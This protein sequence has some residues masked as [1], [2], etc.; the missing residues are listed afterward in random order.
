MRHRPPN[1]HAVQKGRL[2][3]LGLAALLLAA[4]LSCSGGA[5]GPRNVIVVL[6][7]TLRADHLGCYG[8][9]RGATP[10][11]DRFAAEGMRLT[12]ARTAVPLT[13]PSIT[14][15]MTSTYPVYHGIQV[16]MSYALSD[17]AVTMAEVFREHGYRTAAI[18]GSIALDH[19]QGLTQ[20]FD[21]YDD[22]FAG[23]ERKHFAGEDFISN[24]LGPPTMRRAETVFD[25]GLEW[26]DAEGG[27]PFFLFLHLFDAHIPYDS[28]VK[29]PRDAYADHEVQIWAYDSEIHYV[30][31]EFGRFLRGLEERGMLDNTLVIFT[32][33]HGEGLSEHKEMTHGHFLYE[34]TMRV[35]LIFHYPPRIPAGAVESSTFRTIDLMPTILDLVGIGP[36][37][38]LQGVSRKRLVLGEEEGDAAP[39]E[40][41]FET[42]YNKVYLGWSGMRGVQSG[43]WKYIHAPRPEL[44]NLR[45]DPHERRNLAGRMPEIVSAMEERLAWNV[46]EYSPDSWN[47][48]KEIPVQD[49]MKIYLESLGYLTS[50]SETVDEPDSLLPDPKDMIDEF[51]RSQEVTGM[52]NAAGLYIQ[53]G[54][55][56]EGIEVLES[57]PDSGYKNWLIHYHLGLAHMGKGDIETAEAEL[58]KALEI[59]E[60]GPERVQIRD[61]L[62]YIESLR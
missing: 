8:Y 49:E 26:V 48:S 62:R 60:V 43:E 38:G 25:K 40:S 11:I 41:Y 1:V 59:A 20:G 58:R 3:V 14:S 17:T 2:P 4:A 23:D 18:I 32:A 55:F 44:Y 21:L 51:N 42:F 7:D 22:D 5:R 12:K 47:V 35:P 19:R 10:N 54:R 15:I 52:I 27:G 50:P 53:G 37:A 28:P 61:A 6:V 30:D 56:D 16:N 45:E 36:V 57:L 9:G 29:L 13:L 34:S 33:D 31:R 46:A 24:A 39:D